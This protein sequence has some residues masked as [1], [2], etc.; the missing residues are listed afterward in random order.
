M[1]PPGDPSGLDSGV[2]CNGV[3]SALRWKVRAARLMSR[4]FSDVMPINLEH[5]IKIHMALVDR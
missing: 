4:K 3:V 1:D 2:M 5:V